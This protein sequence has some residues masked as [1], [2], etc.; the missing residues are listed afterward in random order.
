MP[1]SSL[2]LCDLTTSSCRVYLKG[3][4]AEC[5]YR[6][7]EC[8]SIAAFLWHAPRLETPSLC[9]T[10]NGLIVLQLSWPF[11]H[12]CSC[13]CPSLVSCLKASWWATWPLIVHS[14]ALVL[15]TRLSQFSL[16]THSFAS[17]L[18]VL[19]KSLHLHTSLG[20]PSNRIIFAVFS[21]S[22]PTSTI[23]FRWPPLS[24]SS[25]R[26][27]LPATTAL[28]AAYP[29]AILLLSSI[30]RR[31]AD[32]VLVSTRPNWPTEVT[33]TSD[34]SF[35]TT[36]TALFPAALRFHSIYRYVF[37]ILSSEQDQVLISS[38][39]GYA[40]VARLSRLQH[41]RPHRCHFSKGWTCNQDGHHHCNCGSDYALLPGK[42]IVFHNRYLL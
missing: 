18:H 6:M 30:R 40:T 42:Y 20:C 36:L 27:N 32:R 39:S 4:P 26:S 38:T 1:D 41:R 14:I 3:A 2:Y 13:C 9:W 24:T 19:R 7:V 21:L 15:R 11:A 33:E 35:I 34:S 28:K 8:H 29:L 12:F 22:S 16:V 5:E 31:L 23:H 17:T 37:L 25:P 10:Y